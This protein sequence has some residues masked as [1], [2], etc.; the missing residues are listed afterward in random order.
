M[1]VFAEHWEKILRM[2]GFQL[3]NQNLFYSAKLLEIP[4]PNENI[5]YLLLAI[6]QEEVLMWII[7]LYCSS[8]TMS[9]LKKEM[10]VNYKQ[11]YS[12]IE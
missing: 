9:L 12:Q 11:P 3:R 1:H 5:R 8:S 2:V 4:I 6:L 10:C 7:S